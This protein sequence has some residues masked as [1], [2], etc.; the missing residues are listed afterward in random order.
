MTK[1]AD[2]ETTQSR[3]TKLY[4]ALTSIIFVH[5]LAAAAL[6]Y[7]VQPI[8]DTQLLYNWGAGFI[9]VFIISFILKAMYN[10]KVNETNRNISKW[11]NIYVV[12]NLLYTLVF[13]AA[14][15]YVAF[16]QTPDLT[17]TVTIIM[18]M[19]VACLVMSN[20][21]SRQTIIAV[22]I[23]LVLSFSGALVYFSAPYAQE[24]T[25]SLGV[26]TSL[27][28]AI[29]FGVNRVYN[30]A[31]ASSQILA[32]ELKENKQIRAKLENNSFIDIATNIYNR[33]F[34]DL[35]LDEKIRRAKRVGNNLS[36]A[37]L[38]V[39][40]FNEYRNHYGQE[41]TQKTMQKI[42]EV[43]SNATHRGGEYMTVF[44]DNKFA[45]IASN[46][47]TKEAVAFTGKMAQLIDQAD[48]KNSVSGVDDSEKITLS[49]GIS[50][51]QPGNIIDVDEIILQ[52]LFALETAHT[53]G[54]NNIQ[55]YDYKNIKSSNDKKT[56]F[57][58][59]TT[60]P[61]LVTD[62]PRSA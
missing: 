16:L 26:F 20:L 6:I 19:Q 46:V 22:T 14:Y 10:S 61:Y 23:P 60:K 62:E 2:K 4:S 11:A 38:E 43:L 7:S 36:L 47:P 25:I 41:K 21:S 1:L 12:I 50:E 49:I 53:L 27:L 35:M 57:N 18:A 24:L 32:K 9:S 15:S 5:I 51:F 48:I 29:T 31:V 52:A 30:T 37:I 28:V 3:V 33:R 39:D 13:A 59:P 8:I 17:L 58:S 44:D 54:H 40:F 34:F 45:L 42:A 56:A 55:V